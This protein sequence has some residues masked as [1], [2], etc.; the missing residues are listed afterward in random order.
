MTM[1]SLINQLIL[2]IHDN[3]NW[4]RNRKYI[5]AIYSTD[6]LPLDLLNTSSSEQYCIGCEVPISAMNL[7]GWVK[8]NNRLKAF[9]SK[10]ECNPSRIGDTDD[11]Q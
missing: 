11:S 6:L 5:Y 8:R 10:P 3:L 4:F 9:C 1:F 7:G 2:R